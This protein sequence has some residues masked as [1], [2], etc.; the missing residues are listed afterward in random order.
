MPLLNVQLSDE[1]L[2]SRFYA[3]THSGKY[4]AYIRGYRC[5]NDL[6]TFKEFSAAFQ[7]PYYFGMNAAALDECLCDLSWLS[8]TGLFLMIDHFES[9][10]QGSVED[11]KWLCN[12]LQRVQD[13][14]EQ[15][16][17][18]M[19]ILINFGENQQKRKS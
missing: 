2:A 8:F 11:Q 4:A 18:E 17:I 16:E 13:W 7:F 9:V 1:E 14:W 6:E 19:E 10:Y 12:F 3:A 15:Q 5:V